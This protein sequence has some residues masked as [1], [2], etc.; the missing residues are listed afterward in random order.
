MAIDPKYD[1]AY[2]FSEGVAPVE[3]AGSYVFIDKTEN[4]VI[5]GAFQPASPFYEGL[6]L[7]RVN[8]KLGFIHRLG[9]FAIDKAQFDGASSF[10]GGMAAVNI[11]GTFTRYSDTLNIVDRQ[12]FC[13]GGKW[14]F[15]L[16]PM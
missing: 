3:S 16:N 1:F 7:V 9:Q 2:H 13:R 14:G 11:G 4:V 6:A 10:A 15:V 5:P 12:Y 8:D